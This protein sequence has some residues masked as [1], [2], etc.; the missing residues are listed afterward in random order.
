MT[1][2]RTDWTMFALSQNTYN[3]STARN[4]PK[5]KLWRNVG[6]LLTYKCN[7]ACEFCYYHCSPEKSGLMP[8]DTAIAAWQSLK[9]LADDNAKVH[10]TGGEPFLH[11]DRLCEIL[12]EAKKQELGP[13]DL[14]ETN[15]FWATDETIVTQRLTTL[16]ELGMARLKISVDPFHQEYVD[17]ELARRL[18]KIGADVLGPK[19]IQVRWRKYLNDTTNIRALSQPDK[20]KL[21][22]KAMQDYPCRFTGRAADKLAR[23]VAAK[24][25]DQLAKLN[26]KSAFLT[27]K[28]I[29]IDPFGNVFSGT[30]SGIILGHLNKTPLHDIWRQFHPTNDKMIDTLFNLGP[31]GLL[32]EAVSLGYTPLEHYADKCHLCTCLRQFLFEK[33]LDEP[34]LGPPDCYRKL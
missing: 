12:K 26:C 5:F 11:W 32:D 30:C 16:D 15:G 8:V 14:V 3:K 18:A 1:F 13:V 27:A 20:N 28:G 23:L 29:H 33:A 34:T 6:L 21:Y 10:I 22:M 4:E 7:S 19:H 2:V 24:T 9:T 31:V 17:I 25:I